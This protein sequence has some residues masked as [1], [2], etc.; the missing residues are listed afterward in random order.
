MLNGYR[1]KFHRLE[2]RIRDVSREKL[3]NLD[4]LGWPL[5]LHVSIDL[6][7]ANQFV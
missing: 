4:D 6:L 7:D 5:E 3:P 2:K 1:R